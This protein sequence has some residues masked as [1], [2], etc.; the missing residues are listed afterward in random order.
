[1]RTLVTAATRPRDGYGYHFFV[2]LFGGGGEAVLQKR[3][4]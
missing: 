3:T 2:F 1:M 4:L